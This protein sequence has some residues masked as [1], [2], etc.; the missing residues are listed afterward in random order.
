MKILSLQFS[1]LN[2]LKGQ[3][4]IDFRQAPFADNGVFAITGPTGAGK[5]TLLDAICLALYHETPRLGALSANNNEIMTRGTA[6]CSAEVEFEVKGMAYRAFWS[7][8]RSHGK[9][10]GK[11]QAAVVELGDVASEKVLASQI[12]K[13]SELIEQITGLDFG[14]FTKS[15]MLSQGEFAAFL[16]ADE[17]QRAE[18]LE[19]LTGTEIYGLISERVHQHYSQAKQQLAELEAQAKGVQ[20]L[21]EDQKQA[22]MDEQ[23]D[24]QGQQKERQIHISAKQE[25]VNWWQQLD[26]AQSAQQ[27]ATLQLT[28][29]QHEKEQQKEA[30]QR[31]ANSHPSEALRAPFELLT[32]AQAQC[33]NDE[34][35]LGQS[36]QQLQTSDASLAQSKTVSVAVS[37]EFQAIKAT[38]HAQ[39]TL[40]N[41]EVIPLDNEIRQHQDQLTQTNAQHAQLSTKHAQLVQ[42]VENTQTGINSQQQSL[43]QANDYLTARPSDEALKQYLGQWQLQAQQIKKEQTSYQQ[44]AEKCKQEQ[45]QLH[46]AQQDAQ[47]NQQQHE[48]INQQTRELENEFQQQTERL[49]K[50]E[51]HGAIDP[52]E[53]QLSTL[54]SLTPSLLALKNTQQQWQQQTQELTEKQTQLADNLAQQKNLSNEREVIKRQYLAKSQQV[55]LLS[56]LIS[57]EEQLIHFR[58][59]LKDEHP[60]PLCGAKEHPLTSEMAVDI[61]DTVTQKQQQESELAQLEEQGKEIRAKLDAFLRGETELRQRIDWLST[62]QAQLSQTWPEMCQALSPLS[63]QQTN[64]QLTIDNADSLIAIENQFNQQIQQLQ[65]Q[66]EKLKTQA[67]T[68]LVSKEKWQHSQSQSQSASSALLLAQQ[69][70]KN[71]ENSA[72]NLSNDIQQAGET[73]TSLSQSLLTHIQQ[74]GYTPPEADN[75]LQWLTSKEQDAKQ[76]E[77]HD[78][79]RNEA[80]VQIDK[81][82]SAQQ[83]QLSLSG[84]TKS[85]LTAIEQQRQTLRAQLESL[86]TKR[87]SLFA[88]KSVKTERETLSETL[89]T[90]EARHEHAQ[91]QMRQKEQEHNTHLANVQNAQTQLQ[92][93]QTR[94]KTRQN[95]WQTKLLA[96]PF[97]DQQAFEAALLDEA[98]RATLQTLKQTLDDNLA[99]YQALLEQ[100]NTQVKTLLAHNNATQWQLQTR[101]AV[102]EALNAL[103]EEQHKGNKRE[104]EISQAL[105]FDKQRSSEQQSLFSQIELQRN[106]F[107]HIHYLHSLIGSQKGDKFRTFA[108][109][110]T[111]DNLMYLANKQLERLHGRYLLKRKAD[112]SLALSV[113]DTWQGDIQRDTKTLSGGE[114]FL[115]SLALALALSELVSHK[116]SIDSLF[117]DEGFGTLDSE[118]LDI[119]LDA[120]DNLH[121]SGKMIGVISHVEAMKERI[122]AQLAVT[123]KSGLGVS[124]LD[125]R[126]AVR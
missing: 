76:W 110:L 112:A 113:I 124:E 22:L 18:L 75:L 82:T 26:S 14:R 83:H 9:P 60:C 65:K 111:L 27:Q 93:N 50:L 30:L 2:S 46:L 116:T 8:R 1:N 99:K 63:D 89:R 64:L 55:K 29:A 106:E 104:G 33:I 16:N 90:L 54:Q 68:L 108:Q 84:D 87:F 118:T 10:D 85:Q 49:S 37:N 79:Q 81:L 47:L 73:L 40:L 61:P 19:E 119:A 74:H 62:Q 31:L 125:Q 88:D 103:T 42:D 23:Q 107:E 96:S 114:S 4:K 15:M 43:K 102:I 41:E 3:W 95:E 57:Q 25:H 34:K 66:I 115:V 38:Y 35:A 97:A 17:K 98:T 117:L 53:R 71:L 56:Q 69:S 11:L 91:Q 121:A 12:K 28:Q 126:Y 78:N 44:L 120:L 45:R 6:E 122:V 39:E 24:L 109:G 100:A 32:D 48:K 7:M 59:A 105:N 51:E 70:A 67:R 58:A 72:Q 123:K 36:Q 5:T 80:T 52:Q 13:K 77:H 21:S 94:L 101:D 86:S 92:Q 20:L